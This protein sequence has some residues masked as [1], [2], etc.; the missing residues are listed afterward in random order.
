MKSRG[1]SPVRPPHQGS[2][3]ADQYS[4]ALVHPIPRTL[5]ASSSAYP[6]PPSS[7][8]AHPHLSRPSSPSS[9]LSSSSSAIFERDMEQPRNQ[10]QPHTLNHK[11]SRLS[12]LSHGSALDHTV[13]AVLDDAF[14]ALAESTSK[15][16]IDGLEIVAPTSVVHVPSSRKASI[17][18]SSMAH[19]SRSPSPASPVSASPAQSPPILAQL[20]TQLFAQSPSGNVTGGTSPG[21]GSATSGNVPKPAERISTNRQLPGG[22]AF[23]GEA[24]EPQEEFVITEPDEVSIKSVMI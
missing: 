24:N 18:P 21:T 11:T 12:H 7:H 19:D 9:Y 5:S 8:H 23:G 3:S 20:Q 16:G 13:P 2:P 17:R 1:P 6:T 10:S 15:T 4:P 14:E 22:W